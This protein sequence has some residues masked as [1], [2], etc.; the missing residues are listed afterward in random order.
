MNAHTWKAIRIIGL[1]F[2]V[3][4]IIGSAAIYT[5][6]KE[7]VIASPAVGFYA[8]DFTL[9][10]LN[11]TS[12]TLS[13]HFGQPM[14][15]TLWASW[16]PPCKAEMPTFNQAYESFGPDK[17]L[18]VGVNVAAQDDLNAVRKFVEDNQISFPILLDVNAD[19][20]NQYQLQGLPMTFFINAEG[21]IEE[22]FV[23]GPLPSSTVRSFFTESLQ[24]Q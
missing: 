8:P 11:G 3:G 17:V 24:E 18:V 23:G 1:I 9:A 19:V 5:P 14:I 20:S 2:I 22:V 4:W 16:C 12:F 7:E 6:P 10:D 15:L 21:I 13:D